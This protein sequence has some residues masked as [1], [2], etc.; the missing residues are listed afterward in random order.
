[1]ARLYVDNDDVAL[2]LSG[3][4]AT[5]AECKREPADQAPEFMQGTQLDFATKDHRIVSINCTC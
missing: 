3:V 2:R 1:M 5:S 4:L